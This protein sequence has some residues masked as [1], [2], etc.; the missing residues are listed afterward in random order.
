MHVSGPKV[1][2][3]KRNPVNM[4]QVFWQ[5]M[6]NL[7]AAVYIHVKF[8]CPCILCVFCFMIFKHSLYAYHYRF[9]WT[10]Q[11]GSCIHTLSDLQIPTRSTSEVSIQIHLRSRP[12]CFRV[13][14]FMLNFWREL[15]LYAFL[16]F[17][18]RLLGS[19]LGFRCR[20][21]LWMRFSWL[22]SLWC[23]RHTCVCVLDPWQEAQ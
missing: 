20:N 4:I 19:S 18:R 8:V 10:H 11:Q 5:T 12:S 7:D 23:N 2:L 14:F 1:T 6:F 22:K 9:V 3:T 15:L 16:L 13:F 17:W 21:D